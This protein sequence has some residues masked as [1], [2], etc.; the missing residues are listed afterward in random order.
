[1]PD[2]AVEL[3]APNGLQYVQPVGLFIN[4]EFVESSLKEKL[5]TIDPA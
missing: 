3:A 4:N 5:T 1:M 2:L